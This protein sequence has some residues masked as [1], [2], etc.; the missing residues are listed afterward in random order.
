MAELSNLC[1]LAQVRAVKKN[2][3]AASCVFTFMYT[4]ACY[5]PTESEWQCGL[6][7]VLVSPN[8]TK[9]AFFSVAFKRSN[10]IAGG[11]EQENNHLRS[12]VACHCGGVLGVGDPSSLQCR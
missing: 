1:G 9:A 5:E 2:R 4:D 12:R 3:C 7:G 6:G 10:G 11:C 8:G